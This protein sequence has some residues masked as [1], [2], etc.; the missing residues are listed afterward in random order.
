MIERKCGTVV[1]VSSIVGRISIPN[2]SSYTA[3][4]HALQAFADCLRAE[5]AH[6][7]VHVMVSSPGYVATDVSQNALTG[8]GGLHGGETFIS[9]CFD[10]FNNVS[11]NCNKN[12]VWLLF[13]CFAVTDP[14]TAQGQKPQEYAYHTVRAILREDKEIVPWKFVPVI[15]LRSIFPSIY[16]QAMKQRAQ[17]IATQR[18]N[19][20]QTV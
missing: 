10:N 2:R 20:T 12:R 16:F 15:L 6:H 17:K 1:F 11:K 8:Y 18:L 14:E 19:A 13:F 7:N 4:K 5:I 3:A 9:K